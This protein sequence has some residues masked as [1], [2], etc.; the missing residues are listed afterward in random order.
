MID[1]ETGAVLDSRTLSS[2]QDGVYASWNVTGHVQFRITSL[3]GPDA[4]V[5]GVFVD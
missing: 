3:S 5:S 1:V 4:V 2:F